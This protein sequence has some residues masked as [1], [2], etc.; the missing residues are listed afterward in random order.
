MIIALVRG[1]AEAQG[2][3]NS[4]AQSDLD[5]DARPSALDSGPTPICIFYFKRAIL[6]TN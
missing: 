1:E 5:L 2:M 3:E 4:S 6:L